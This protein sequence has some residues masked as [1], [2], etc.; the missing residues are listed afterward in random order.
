MSFG[1]GPNNTGEQNGQAKLSV[2][3]ISLAIKRRASGER[4]ID[5]ANEYGVSTST[6]SRALRGKTWKTPCGSAQEAGP[7]KNPAPGG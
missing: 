3:K 5:L 7:A 6:L 1:L 2:K 4:L